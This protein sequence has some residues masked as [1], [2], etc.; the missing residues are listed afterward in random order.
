MP[1]GGSLVLLSPRQ[2]L[3]TTPYA[4]Y[5]YDGAG[6]VGTITAVQSGYG[7]TGG[8]TS[9]SVTLDVNDNEI[10]NRVSGSCAAGQMMT[11]V[12]Q[13]GSI[14]C[15]ADQNN[16]YQA[17]SDLSLVGNTFNV[18][19]GAGN[20]LDADLLD[21]Q[22]AAEII[23]AANSEVRI[24]IDA[25][26]FTINQPGS[27]YLTQNLNAS[28]GSGNRGIQ[29]AWGVKDVT[30]DFMGFAMDGNGV[31]DH[32]IDNNGS[33]THITIR[34]GSIIN[35]GYSGI[36]NSETFS[37][38]YFIEN[39]N[40]RGNGSAGSNLY[41]QSGIIL[42]GDGHTIINS[43]VS[44]NTDYGIYLHSNSRVLHSTAQNNGGVG[45]YAA[46]GSLISQNLSH[47]NHGYGIRATRAVISNNTASNN[48]SWGFFADGQVQ[49]NENFSFNNN[50]SNDSG[51]GG[52]YLGGNSHAEGNVSTGDN[53][54]GFH[55][56]INYTLYGN[57]V[58]HSENCFFFEFNLGVAKENVAS[59]CTTDFAG[60]TPPAARFIDNFN[61]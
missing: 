61:W 43:T 47:E 51:A 37:S 9:G 17:G 56:R 48:Q 20:G 55:A 44:D 7:L 30:L 38:H 28:A 31:A 1:A 3:N 4:E 6:G 26:P 8:G 60:S 36:K 16:T 35:F 14:N 33:N 41:E 10:Q 46:D 50:V 29:L 45:I 23:A 13:D 24:A 59:S 57:T 34:N 19:S 18:N 21:G 42:V 49:L 54:T 12:N 52:I 5:A 2:K 25:L 40:I 15:Q 27:Y 22:E 11:S 58:N 32:G 39:M 53:V